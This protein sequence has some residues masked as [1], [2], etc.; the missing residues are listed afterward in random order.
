MSMRTTVQS[1]AASFAFDK[2]NEAQ[3]AMA[4]YQVVMGS[5]YL[6]MQ[7]QVQFET[8]KALMETFGGK[9]KAMSDKILSPEDFA[10]KQEAVA[11]D[12][13]MKMMQAFAENARVTGV[14]PELG[15]IMQAAP[16]AITAGQAAAFNPQSGAQ[17]MT[18]QGGM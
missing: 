18:A 15:E 1:R 11:E 2:A 13:M 16:Q 9:W 12:V 3:K 4:A 10:K 14:Q 5:P 7:P 8:L 6:A 17:E